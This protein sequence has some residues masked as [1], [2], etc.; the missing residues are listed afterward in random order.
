M[1]E[2]LCADS[3]CRET[4]SEPNLTQPN[5]TYPSDSGCFRLRPNPKL[6]DDDADGG[7][8]TARVTRTREKVTAREGI[9]RVSYKRTV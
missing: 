5:L 1:R 2:K 7:K 6:T 8:L 9:L 3:K 4:I